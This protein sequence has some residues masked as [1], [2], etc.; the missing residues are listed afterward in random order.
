M[1]LSNHANI[2]GLKGLSMNRTFLTERDRYYIETSIKEHIS[3][4]DIAKILHKDRSCIYRE[5]KRGTVEL[6]NSD[7][8]V[9]KEY[10]AD[11]AQNDYEKKKINHSPGLKIDTELGLHDYIEKKIIQE[12]YSPYA[13]SVLLKQ[14]PDFITKLDY[15][16]IYRY[17]DNG[18]F[19]N[20]TNSHLPVKRNV[21]R[22]Y[23]R[24]TV[25]LNNL[26]GTSIEDRPKDILDRSEFGH[27]ELDS[28]IGKPTVSK[29]VLTV[30]TE[31]KTRK[32]I[33][34]KSK[35]KSSASVVKALD[36]LER[37]FGSK[38]F[39]TIFKSITVDNGSEFLD[40]KSM[41]RSCLTKQLRTKVYYCHPYSSYERGSNENQNRLVRRWYPKG[42]NLDTI[43]KDDIRLLNE[44]INNLPRKLFNGSTSEQLF[45]NELS[46]IRS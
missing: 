37:K 38:T 40:F 20:L 36:A 24:R 25:S 26:K 28:V 8:T 1:F 3:V 19:I 18:V 2:Q 21:K 43:S 22:E 9:R 14:D 30:F 17:I 4:S 35:D 33:V 31:R 44:W 23:K 32:E 7:L 13:V 29:N 6:L 46:L 41:E 12:K 27:W 39:R 16:T 34:I 11:Y 42:Y 5:I 15:R 45:Q 10:L